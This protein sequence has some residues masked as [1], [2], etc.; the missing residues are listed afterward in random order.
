M[1]FER[2]G[3]IGQIALTV[4]D[5]ERAT[6]FYRDA[7]GL[8][9]LFAAPPQLAF[10][11]CAGVRLMLSAPEGGSAPGGGSVL[12]FKVADIDEAFAT[13]RGRDVAFV[14]EPH[15]I[16]KLA[17]GELWMTFFRDPAGNLLALM[18]ERA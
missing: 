7:L 10:F 8:P 4:D 3:S 13:L 2:L 14:D 16:A 18:S 12:Y 5:V 9:F 15:L 6:A 17:T 11:D 1:A